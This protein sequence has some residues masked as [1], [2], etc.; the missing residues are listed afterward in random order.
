MNNGNEHA[1]IAAVDEDTQG[2]IEDYVNAPRMQSSAPY[3]EQ[4]HVGYARMEVGRGASQA[5][6]LGA[7][8]SE[9]HLR[10]IM[11]REKRRAARSAIGRRRQTSGKIQLGSQPAESWEP[12][13]DP[14]VA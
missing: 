2:T 8:Q 4:K 14:A 3:S 10:Q 5:K 11:P 1:V 6:H 12:I 13:N 9:S 7:Q